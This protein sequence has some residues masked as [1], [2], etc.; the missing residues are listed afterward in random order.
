MTGDYT[1]KVTAITPAP[2]SLDTGVGW[3]FK[4]SI[5][6]D[7]CFMATL[8]VTAPSDAQEYS[9]T[10]DGAILSLES[11]AVNPPECS[12]TYTCLSVVGNDP[13]VTCGDAGLVSLDSDTGS[14]SFNSYDMAKY[15]PGEYTF[16]IR[17][18]ISDY[19]SIMTDFTYTIILTD[20]CPTAS[21]VT[22]NSRP[23]DDMVYVL[24]EAEQTQRFDVDKIVK[25]NTQVDCGVVS[26]VFMDENG[27]PL[28][29]TFFVVSDDP[30]STD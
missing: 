16:T 24:G 27:A 8:S 12:V 17:A 21:F 14:L 9:Y 29:N 25:L 3:E 18:S 5:Y 30:S 11:V 1:V 6:S 2:E 13:D 20:P 7:Y 26:F 10:S 15:S 23:F 22:L 28:D 19:P 4:V